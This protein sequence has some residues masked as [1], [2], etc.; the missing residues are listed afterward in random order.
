MVTPV[1]NTVLSS[2]GFFLY[3]KQEKRLIFQI[4]IEAYSNIMIVLNTFL[5]KYNL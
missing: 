2:I 3:C 5:T 4:K 1:I